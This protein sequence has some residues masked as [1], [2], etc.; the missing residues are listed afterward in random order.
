MLEH[1][2]FTARPGADNGL[3]R[4]HRQRQIHA[5]QSHP[6]FLRRERAAASLLDGVDVRDIPQHELRDAIG[7]VPQ[8]GVLFSGDIA[9]NLRYGG[10]DAA[11]R[12]RC[13]GPPRWPRPRNSSTS[14]RRALT[15]PSARAAPTFPADRRQRLSIARAL[16]KKA[17]VY[18]FDDTFSALDFK[19]DAKLRKALTG[20]HRRRHRA[21]R[22]T[23]RFH[24]HARRTDRGAGRG[25]RCGHRHAQ[26]AAGK[27]A[28]PTVRSRESQ[29]S[30]E[31][32]A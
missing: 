4:L 23:A 32:L 22:G 24:H 21:H 20:L 2:T 5:Y 6:P 18:I 30:K 26:G 28:R 17:P 11:T 13:A 7:Y 10:E 1:V 9:S 12:M 3:H 31:E 8:K 27:P 19:T 29:L 14:C 15:P 25:P 16:V